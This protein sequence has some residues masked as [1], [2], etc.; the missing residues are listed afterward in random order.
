MIA[1]PKRLQ[2]KRER[3]WRAP[4]SAV[5]VGRGSCYGNCFDWQLYMKNYGSTEREAKQWAKNA[6]D[7][8]WSA[9]AHDDYAPLLDA[10]RGRDLMCWCGPDDPCHADILLK[11]ANGP[12]ANGS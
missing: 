5:Y 2:R 10:I 12:S 11:L 1:M 3:G 8:V 9:H 4:P 6:F 7:K